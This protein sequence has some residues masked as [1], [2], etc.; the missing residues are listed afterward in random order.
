[1]IFGKNTF[2]NFIKILADIIP[3]IFPIIVSLGV[4]NIKSKR[5][6]YSE[7]LALT[8]NIIK[9]KNILLLFS[10]KEK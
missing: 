1:M 9:K 10:S 5:S 8:T 7:F 3:E 2:L 6:I 4:K